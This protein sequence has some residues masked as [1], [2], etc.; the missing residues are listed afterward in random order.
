MCLMKPFSL[1]LAHGIQEGAD[2]PAKLACC[3][4][5]QVWQDGAAMNESEERFSFT[6]AAP[7]TSG[8]P[9]SKF[10]SVFREKST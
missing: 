2:L 1:L 6:R 9:Q 7:S 8:A 5:R 4:L 3:P 10:Y